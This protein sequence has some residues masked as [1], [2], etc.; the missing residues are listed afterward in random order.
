[1][2]IPF[3]TYSGKCINLA[4][5]KEDDICIEDIAHHLS[6]TC[7]Y[8]GG[9]KR[10]YSVAEHTIYLVRQAIKDGVPT[11]IQKQVLLH[12]AAEAYIGD[13]VYHL[14]A[15]FPLFRDMD[16][17]ITSTIMKKFGVI[18]TDFT[19]CKE[20]DRR[21]CIDEMY[22][23]M[24]KIDPELFTGEGLRQ[25]GISCVCFDPIDAEQKFLSM[26]AVLGLY[27]DKTKQEAVT[28]TNWKG[29]NTNGLHDF[30]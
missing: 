13:L 11:D 26:A 27:N 30:I 9:T 28:P 29:K 14:K 2:N 10:F 17:L 20:I 23:L 12:D 1:M 24:Q 21:I 8:N 15:Q 7:R 5:I 18:S 6:Q 16:T 25:L 22:Q 3:Y 19:Y 4:A